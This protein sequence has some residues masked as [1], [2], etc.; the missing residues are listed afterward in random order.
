MSA[1]VE[2]RRLLGNPAL[3]IGIC[4]VL[5]LL[6]IGIFGGML[7]PRDPNAGT[8]LIIRDLPNGN[9][10]IRV[11]PTYPDP[12]HWFGTDQ[13]GR[14]QWSRV[15]AGARLTLTVVLAATL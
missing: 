13:L 6:A 4:C 5:A 10:A 3:M 11:P 14:D 1:R 12:E 2:L 7:A 15:L 8:S 9:T